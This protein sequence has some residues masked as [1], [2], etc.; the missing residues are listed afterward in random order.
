M[1]GCCS[2]GFGEVK[3]SN[4]LLKELFVEYEE[5]PRKEEGDSLIG[6]RSNGL[7]S[8]SL[9]AWLPKKEEFELVREEF[10]W[11]RISNSSSSSFSLIGSLIEVASEIECLFLDEVG[12]LFALTLV[13][14]LVWERDLG[15]S[16]PEIL[17]NISAYGSKNNLKG[18]GEMC[19]FFSTRWRSL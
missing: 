3:S 5:L 4:K 14:F 19:L 7:G 10:V 18:E 6:D 13:C 15:E 11:G 9:V 8:K 1:L 2:L 17:L 12:F 16:I